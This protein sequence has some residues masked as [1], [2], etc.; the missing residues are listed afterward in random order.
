MRQADELRALL[1]DDAL[2]RL[3]FVDVGKG[4]RLTFELAVRSTLA[5]LTRLTQMMDAGH[6][7]GADRWRQLGGDIE[8]LHGMAISEPST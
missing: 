8:R 7:V 4:S 6:V 1:R 2:P 3:G 5:D